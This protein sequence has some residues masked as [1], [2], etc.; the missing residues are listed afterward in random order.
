[1]KLNIF[2][3]FDSKETINYHVCVN[4]IMRNSSLPVTIT[5]LILSQLGGIFTRENEGTTEFS[6]TR[7]LVP[8]L[9]NYEGW[10]IFMDCDMILN[11][12]IN[13][14]WEEIR[15]EPGKAVYVCQHDYIPK[16]TIKAT[17]QQTAYPRK[18]WSSFI[19][20]NNELCRSL[21]PEYVNTA[22]GTQLHRFEWIDDTMIGSLPLSWNWL[23]GEYNNQYTPDVLHYTLGTPCFKDYVDSDYA[24]VWIK[25]FERTISPVEGPWCPPY[26]IDS[27]S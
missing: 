14:I 19:L 9:S 18:N 23:V 26:C 12:D 22:T 7:F 1:M 16:T 10:S 21:T 4:S 17:G 13:K 11:T 15:F 5:P 3:G 2:I 20:F 27:T 24:D 6:M 8:Y 25:E